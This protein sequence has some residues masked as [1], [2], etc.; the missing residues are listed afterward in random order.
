MQAR[1]AACAC[2]PILLYSLYLKGF[3]AVNIFP[4]VYITIVVNKSHK[5]HEQYRHWLG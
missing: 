3:V 5:I 2:Q 4:E 1:M